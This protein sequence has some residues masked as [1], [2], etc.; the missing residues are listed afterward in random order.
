MLGFMTCETSAHVFLMLTKLKSI[1][2]EKYRFPK[3]Y[4]ND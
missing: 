2:L 3:L 4:S 1:V